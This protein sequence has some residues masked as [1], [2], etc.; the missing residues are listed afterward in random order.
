M[1]SRN[2]VHLDVHTLILLEAIDMLRAH[3]RNGDE[4][5]HL[6]FHF[7]RPSLGLFLVLDALKQIQLVD[8]LSSFLGSLY[9]IYDFVPKRYLELTHRLRPA[10]QLKHRTCRGLPR[11]AQNGGTKAASESF[12]KRGIKFQQYSYQSTMAFF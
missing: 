7:T 3:Y 6:P 8:A 11:N 1:P 2:I 5:N 4:L 9:H 10:G 12:F